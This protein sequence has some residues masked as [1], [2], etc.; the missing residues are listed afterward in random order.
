MKNN[1]FKSYFIT[2]PEDYHLNKQVFQKCSIDMCCFRDKI[3]KDDTTKKQ[4]AKQFLTDATNANI[5]TILINSNITL[6][7]KLNFDGV[8]LTSTQFDKIQFAKQ[9]KLFVIISCHSTKE[10]ELAYKYGANGVTYS[11]IFYK[12][13]KPNPKGLDGLRNAVKKYQ[14]DDFFIIALGGI[15]TYDQ[16]D[17]IKN[18]N[19]Y[20]FSS[21]RY[22]YNK[23]R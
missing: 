10:I 12:Q 3:T 16:I 8:H 19:A 5:K 9:Q 20:G 11:P 4:L 21:I 1:D 18:T 13:D 22:F 6:A 14:N 17:Q 15:I 23:V 7:V 2:S